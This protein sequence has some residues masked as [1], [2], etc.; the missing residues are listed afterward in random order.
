MGRKIRIALIHKKNYNFFNKNHFDQTTDYFFKD[1]LRRNK[2]LEVSYFPC[3]NEFDDLKMNATL[4][5]FNILHYPLSSY[6]VR[7][8]K[9]FILLIAR[10]SS[11]QGTYGSGIC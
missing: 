5:F 3:E 6:L 4:I 9:S 1:A 7:F 8:K 2:L 10:I 11:L